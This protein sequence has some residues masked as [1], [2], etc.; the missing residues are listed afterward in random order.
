MTPTQAGGRG[1]ITKQDLE[2]KSAEEVIKGLPEQPRYCHDRK[3]SMSA[4]FCGAQLNGSN[5]TIHDFQPG[6]GD[7][8]MS[9]F[10]FC[11]GCGREICHKCAIARKP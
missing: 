11:P 7:M 1:V 9:S 5:S 10:K 3:V 8:P 2:I 6:W 4:W